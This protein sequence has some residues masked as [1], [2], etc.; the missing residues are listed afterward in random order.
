MRHLADLNPLE[1]QR[2]LRIAREYRQQGYAVTLYPSSEELPAALA[3]CALDLIATSAAKTV[4]VEVRTRENLTLNGAED[5][6]T[7]TKQVQQVPG[8]E[9]ELVVTNPRKQAS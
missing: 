7:L 6:R 5:L 3:N 2:L 9:F 8:W 4:V 1:H